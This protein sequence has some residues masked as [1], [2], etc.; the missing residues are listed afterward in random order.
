[1]GELQI[2]KNDEFGEIRTVEL[3]GKPYFAE[4]MWQEPW[5]TQSQ[6]MQLPHIARGR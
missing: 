5:G 4:K 2:F 6:K 3:E 1:M